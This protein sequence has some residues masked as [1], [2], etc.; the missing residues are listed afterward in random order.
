MAPGTRSVFLRP[1][2]CAISIWLAG[3]A[4]YHQN[5]MLRNPQSQAALLAQVG[6]SC[7]PIPLGRTCLAPTRRW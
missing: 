4:D 2:G 5:A 7:T 3:L 6:V 1:V